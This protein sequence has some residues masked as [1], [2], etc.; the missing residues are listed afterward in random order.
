MAKT[1]EAKK[2]PVRNSISMREPELFAQVRQV[3]EKRGGPPMAL[4][5]MMRIAL[6]EWLKA[7]K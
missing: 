7:Q 1:L 2:T 3:F 5:L 6:D 4:A